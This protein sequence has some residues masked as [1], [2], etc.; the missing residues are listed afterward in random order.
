MN[1]KQQSLNVPP[2]NNI[3]DIVEPYIFSIDSIS[4]IK[5][6]YINHTGINKDLVLILPNEF[7]Q[8]LIKESERLA[9]HITTDNKNS[10][11]GINIEFD[12]LLYV[13]L[14][15]S[16]VYHCLIT[17]KKNIKYPFSINQV[18]VVYLTLGKD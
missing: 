16:K 12:D 7:E 18:M 1:I 14:K 5:L 3:G 8:T 13:T 9:E 4:E 2:Q 10:I 11:H 17:N 6:N 15:G